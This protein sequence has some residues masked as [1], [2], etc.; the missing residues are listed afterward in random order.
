MGCEAAGRSNFYKA[1]GNTRTDGFSFDES[2][3]DVSINE[4]ATG[5]W[6]EDTITAD[7]IDVRLQFGVA[8]QWHTSPILGLGIQPVN[9]NR[10]RPGYLDALKQQ[11]KITGRFCSLYNHMTPNTTGEIVLGG[12]DASKFQG[13]LAV[14]D[15][16]GIPGEIDAPSVRISN[17]TG[18][19]KG[20]YENLGKPLAIVDPLARSLFIPGNMYTELITTLDAYGLQKNEFNNLALPCDRNYSP[21]DFLE[22]SFNELVIK[23]EFNHLKGIKFNNSLGLCEL[24]VFPTE[25]VLN[26]TKQWSFVLGGPFFRAAYTVLGVET[27][28]TGIGVLNPSPVGRDIIELGGSFGTSLDEIQGGSSPPPSTTAGSG[29][30]LSSGGIA[31][32]VIAVV[33]V[34]V[35]ALGAV[36]FIRRKR[37]SIPDIPSPE[38]YP[39]ELS[40]N[41]RPTSELEAKVAV[42]VSHELPVYLATYELEAEARR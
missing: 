19:F 6:V 11:G 1:A 16:M 31:G 26:I 35:A 13:R 27:N 18:R 3:L 40:P 8:L 41:V 37:K 28:I 33:F 20:P 32:V 14:W 10:R 29:R 38:G 2:Y 12:V 36:F 30:A 15:R 23:I 25:R 4:T 34:L 5:Y 24:S 22:L 17:G 21:D 9:Q 39:S 42:P 7:G